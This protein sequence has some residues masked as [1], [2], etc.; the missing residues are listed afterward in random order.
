VDRHFAEAIQ[1][2]ER[3]GSEVKRLHSARDPK[4]DR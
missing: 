2:L 1:Q 3:A 4:A